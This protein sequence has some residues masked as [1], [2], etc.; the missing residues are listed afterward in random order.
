MK[1][2]EVFAKI[3]NKHEKAQEEYSNA[4]KYIADYI[5]YPRYDHYRR[6]QGIGYSLMVTDCTK[7]PNGRP[8]TSQKLITSDTISKETVRGFVGALEKLLDKLPFKVGT[9][10]L[11]HEYLAD[12]LSNADKVRKLESDNSCHQWFGGFSD[13][14]SFEEKIRRTLGP[15]RLCTNAMGNCHGDLHSDNIMVKV[16]GNKKLPALI[17]FSRAGWTH[18]IKDIVTVEVDMIIRGLSEIKALEEKGLFLPFLKALNAKGSAAILFNKKQLKNKKEFRRAEKVRIII[19]TLRRHAFKKYGIDEIEYFIASVLKALEVLS[20]G[21]LPLRQN[22]RA[23]TYVSFLVD[24][25][26]RSGGR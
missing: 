15:L 10:D 7:G 20:Y 22:E 17:D 12:T 13:G 1:C 25:I 21:K 16:E 18:A 2:K 19:Q 9:G 8:M 14:L 26:G 6:Y 23:T 4:L 5:D 24:Q 3:Y 11:V